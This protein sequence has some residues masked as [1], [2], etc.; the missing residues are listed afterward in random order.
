ML[1]LLDAHGKPALD[2]RIS[3]RDD[4]P[5]APHPQGRNG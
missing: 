2:I 3:S 1:D 5:E 4:Q